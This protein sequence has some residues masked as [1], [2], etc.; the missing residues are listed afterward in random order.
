MNP[1][2]LRYAVFH[3]AKEIL[4]AQYKANLATWELLNKTTKESEGL[5]PSFPTLEE[6]IDKAIQINKFVS[7]S[8]EKELAKAVKTLKGFGAAV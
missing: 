7:D 2:E 5:A 4:E 3:S 1:F 6:I 8:S